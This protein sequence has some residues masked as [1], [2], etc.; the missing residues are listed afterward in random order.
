[1]LALTFANK[2]DYDKIRESDTFDII[3][4][5]GFTPGTPL[6]LVIHH[7]DDNMEET[8]IVNHSYNENQIDWFRAGSALNLIRLNQANEQR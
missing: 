1:M 6:K 2:D 7:Q 8:I 3:G 4:L 5:K